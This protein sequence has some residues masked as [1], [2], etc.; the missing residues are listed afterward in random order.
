MDLFVKNPHLWTIELALFCAMLGT[1]RKC[2]HCQRPKEKAKIKCSSCKQWLTYDIQSLC[3]S[4][5]RWRGCSVSN[6][7][8]SL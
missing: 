2:S 8:F 4:I 5:G 1:S 6:N 7:P 3:W